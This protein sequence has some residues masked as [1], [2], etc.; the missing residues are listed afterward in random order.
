[1][2][3]EALL[4]HLEKCSQE[5][6]IRSCIKQNNFILCTTELSSGTPR[7]SQLELSTLLPDSPVEMSNLFSSVN[8]SALHNIEA[9]YTKYEY[10]ENA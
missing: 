2:N 4:N 8:T 10:T 1:M 6:F 5:E 9:I 3:Y 7:N